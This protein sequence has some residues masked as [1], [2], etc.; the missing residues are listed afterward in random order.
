[1]TMPS[2]SGMSA[3]AATR[4]PSL[5]GG[6]AFMPRRGVPEVTPVGVERARGSIAV[7]L[8]GYSGVAPVFAFGSQP[9]LI[10]QMDG[11]GD[12]SVRDGLDL[13]PVLTV[14]L[15]E[16]SAGTERAQV[17]EALRLSHV[18]GHRLVHDAPRPDLHPVSSFRVRHPNRTVDRQGGK[19]R[20]HRAVPGR[21]R[22]LDACVAQPQ[23]QS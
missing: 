9:H 4:M 13:T 2:P 18:L 23:P 22:A 1:M 19:V 5:I 21:Q 17:V 20:E 10:V 8:T 7:E 14:V 15:F 16:D 12:E 3:T 11:V 6:L